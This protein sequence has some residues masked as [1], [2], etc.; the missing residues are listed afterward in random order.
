MRYSEE[1]LGCLHHGANPTDSL[2]E[3]WEGVR[4]ELYHCL[5]SLWIGCQESFDLW[6]ISEGDLKKNSLI[7][8][9]RV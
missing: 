4:Q 9:S 8:C 6:A 1:S 3:D 2:F 7:I 5:S